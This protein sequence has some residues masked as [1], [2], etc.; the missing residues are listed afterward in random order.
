MVPVWAPSACPRLQPRA[1]TSHFTASPSSFSRYPH[2]PHLTHLSVPFNSRGHCHTFYH[3]AFLAL[4]SKCPTQVPAC[5]KGTARVLASPS[6]SAAR[7][8]LP[9][10]KYRL[11]AAD[12]YV[13]R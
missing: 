3:A 5:S 8:S 10:G 9:L 7:E 1:G 11:G 13:E 2:T 4:F 6:P 12:I